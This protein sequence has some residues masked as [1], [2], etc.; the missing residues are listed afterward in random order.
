MGDGSFIGG[1]LRRAP[2]SPYRG[3][4]GLL[5]QVALLFAAATAGGAA[6]AHAYSITPQCESPPG[7]VL[8][9]CSGWH[10][11]DVRLTWDWEPK[12]ETENSGCDTRKLDTDSTPAGFAEGCLVKWD[13]VTLQATVIIRVDKTPPVITGAVPARPPDHNGWWTHPIDFTFAASDVSSGVA[14]CD[15]VNYPGPDGGGLY[16]SGGCRDVAGNSANATQALNYDAT[17]PSV[18]GLTI[19]RKAGSAVLG[20]QTSPDVVR[21]QVARALATDGVAST[22]VYSGSASVFSDVMLSRDVTYRYTVTAFDEAGNAASTTAISEPTSDLQQ[23]ASSAL[24]PLDGARLSQ[25]PLLRW[26]RVRRARYYNVQLFRDGRKILSAWPKRNRLELSR[27]WRYGG[28]RRLLTRDWYR[29]YVWPG[30]GLPAERDY[31][32]LIGSSR[33]YFRG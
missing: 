22:T 7:T 13:S 28:K 33:F 18:G 23:L 31:G 21:N 3:A 26:K 5:A 14:G 20:W 9:D 2:T 12:P 4:I 27:R 29:W 17:P 1:S 11:T 32:K 6:A 16:V 8:P 10:T 24:R 30:R 25:P 19:L 15:T